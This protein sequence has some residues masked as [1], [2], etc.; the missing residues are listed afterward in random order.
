MA[1]KKQQTEKAKISSNHILGDDISYINQI[2]EIARRRQSL[3]Y[4]FNHIIS[5]INDAFQFADD[6][7]II[8]VFGDVSISSSDFIASQ[9]NMAQTIQTY[10]GQR[11][12]IEIFY[13]KE[14]P[15][16]NEGP[17]TEEE[18]FLLNRVTQIIEK[19]LKLRQ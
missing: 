16:E 17:F 12:Y 18:R 4:T 19:Y 9:W 3:E 11:G 6:I 13:S 1:E 8:I 14:H 5:I 2:D 7:S 10:D 15:N